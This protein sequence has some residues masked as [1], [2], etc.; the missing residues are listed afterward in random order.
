[1][2]I[3]ARARAFGVRVAPISHPE[4]ATM[5]ADL[6][7]EFIADVLAQS[8]IDPRTRALYELC[9]IHRDH[10]QDEIV[11]DKLRMIVRL[12]AESGLAV[13]GFSPE[14]TAH[15]LGQS[16]VDSW[17]AGIATAEQIDPALVFEMHKRVM[18]VFA[19]LPADQARSLASK[20]L[21]FHFP[22]LFFLYDSR[23][24]AAAF[25]I[26]QGECGYLARSEHDPEYGRFFACCRKL[27]ERLAA[28][29][30]RRLNPRELDRVLRACADHQEVACAAGPRQANETAA[31]A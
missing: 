13:P 12:C 8:I 30:G 20:Y 6:S 21:H 11:A 15:R 2:N 5:K 29:A 24:A 3:L 31:Y 10:F 16:G 18:D 27:T 28:P 19:D 17:F 4:P 9:F 14:Y 25:A 7:R 26:G 23:V 22:E 1:M